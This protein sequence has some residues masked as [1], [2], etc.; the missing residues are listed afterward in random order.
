M[1]WGRQR[2]AGIRATGSFIFHPLGIPESEMRKGR[3]L[4]DGG[5]SVGYFVMPRVSLTTAKHERSPLDW[6]AR[7]SRHVPVHGEVA[8]CTMDW[9]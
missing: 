5:M 2:A 4:G 3:H 6:E 8:A 9:R 7:L 1:P